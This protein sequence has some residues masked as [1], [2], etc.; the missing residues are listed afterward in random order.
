MSAAVAPLP[1]RGNVCYSGPAH[2]RETHQRPPHGLHHVHSAGCRFPTTDTIEAV[3]FDLDDCCSTL[4][5]SFEKFS[6]VRPQACGLSRHGRRQWMRACPMNVLADIVPH[7][8][9][10]G[11]MGDGSSC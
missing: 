7:I 10:V 8:E 9:P 6:S 2:G 1:Q 5:L 4:S 3:I 11:E